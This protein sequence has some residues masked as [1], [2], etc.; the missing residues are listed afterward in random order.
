MDQIRNQSRES[1]V[2]IYIHKSFSFKI[3]HYLSVNATEVESPFVE[4]ISNTVRNTLLHVFYRLPIDL[5]DPFE[6]F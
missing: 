3:R 1:G 4:M 5:I 2:S 6:I